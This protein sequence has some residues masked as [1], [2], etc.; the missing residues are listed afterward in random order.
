AKRMPRPHRPERRA[1][2]VYP[3]NEQAVSLALGEVHR[4]ESACSGYMGAA[5]SVM[6]VLL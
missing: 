1:Q 3:V 5:V 4:E 6:M 2:H